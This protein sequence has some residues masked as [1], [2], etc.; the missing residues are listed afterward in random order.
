MQE[1]ARDTW[2]FDGYVV[3]DCGA[4][5]NIGRPRCVPRLPPKSRSDT[6]RRRGPLAHTVRQHNYTQ[7]IDETC[8]LAITAGC[9]LSCI[10]FYETCASAVTVH[11]EMAAFFSRAWLLWRALMASPSVRSASALCC[12]ERVD[13]RV[14]DRPRRRAPV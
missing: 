8:A 14:D 9:E 6:V 1:L 7:T 5:N 10:L 13:A 3:S 2:G 11:F 12:A 4:V